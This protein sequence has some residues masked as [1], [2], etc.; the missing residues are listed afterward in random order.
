MLTAPLFIARDAMQAFARGDEESA[1]P[2]IYGTL[3]ASELTSKRKNWN[4]LIKGDAFENNIKKTIVRAVYNLTEDDSY[5]LIFSIL[6]TDMS[7]GDG[8]PAFSIEVEDEV[9]CPVL[10]ALGTGLGENVK[11]PAMLIRF[12]SILESAGIDILAGVPMTELTDMFAELQE[13]LTTDNNIKADSKCAYYQAY[14]NT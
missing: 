8:K 1:V 14:T 9:K 3:S 7:P 5:P 11:T 10:S 2:S 4:E 12:L 13:S 6:D